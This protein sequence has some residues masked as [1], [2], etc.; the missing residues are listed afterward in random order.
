[1]KVPITW[2]R[3]FV[4]FELSIPELAHRLTLAGLEVEEIRFVGLP[5]PEEKVEGHTSRKRSIGTNVTGLTWDPEKFVVGA[6]LE[7]MP[8]PDADRL[9]LCRLDDG[10]QEHIVLTGAPNLFPYKGQGILKNPLKVAYAREGATLFDGHIAGWETF[11]LKRAKIR[12]VESYSMA[13]SEKE[14]GIS[15]EHEGIIVLDE[16]APTGKPLAEYMG[17]AVLD[18]TLTPNVARNANILGVAREVAALTGSALK[19]PSYEVDGEG[20]AIEGRVSIDIRKP[21]LNPRFVLG[22]VEGVD[23]G[24]SPYW[25]QLRLQL[26]GMRPINN[27][28]D[29]TNY[30][31]LEIGEPLH[32]FDFDVLVERARGEPPEI[33]TRLP[34]SKERINTLDAVERSLDDFTVLVADT[35]G[36]LSIAGVMG[37]AESEVSEKTTRVL[38]EGATWNYINIRRTAGSQNLQS[39]A[40]YRF[41]RG[42]HP[43]MA[44]R[45]VK[46][47]LSWIQQFAGG[48]IAKGLVDEYPLPPEPS[49]VEISPSDV[50]RSLGILLET[51]AIEEIL[52]LLGF[53][54]ERKGDKLQVTTPDHRM[55]IGEGIVGVAD[56]MEEVA[57][58]YGYDRL[59]E[60]MI[61][62]DL[63]PQYSN[64][65]LE[66]EE[67]IRN[68]LAGVDLQEIVTYRLTTPDHETRI[69]P[70][71]VKPDDRPYIQ[72]ENPISVDRVVMRHSLLASVL[73]IVESNARF[74]ERIAV[75]EIG[76]VYLSAE[77]GELPI[78]PLKLA[79]ALT[80]P[81]ALPSWRE[82]SATEFD[83]YDLKGILEA[84]FAGLKV[85]AVEYSPGQHPSFHPGK[86]A[87]ILIDGKQVGV[88]GELHPLVKERYNFQA[89]PLLAAELD[90][91]AVI[92][93]IPESIDVE[94]VK[95]FPPVLEDLAIVVDDA[96]PAEQVLDVIRKS[97]G[98]LLEDIR[99]FD[100]YRGEQIEAGKKS[101]AYA[102]TY[103]ALDRTLTDEEV[104]GLRKKIVKAL[105][106][107]LGAHL[108]S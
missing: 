56:L 101:L 86:C 29:A 20:P 24:P 96:I 87:R 6:V 55:D 82:P 88:M 107:E 74:Q 11:T 103:Q 2:L 99:L 71:G 34:E 73:E 93:A 35:A 78:E 104:A 27:I 26:A 33:I 7:V 16:D 79:I 108:R 22:L 57:R 46:R 89:F 91:E 17:D 83:F 23:V 52:G 100:L 15:E 63:P 68:L 94:L 58:I 69:L 44:E 31:M 80:G 32:A 60:T 21:E 98:E 8:H 61:S 13:C 48:E 1:M 37:G 64:K 102:L 92:R 4:D 95:T 42:I 49:I 81:R 85:G 43:A 19:E 5:L 10:E 59:P 90:V 3:E 67:Q 40:S 45:G 18:I 51:D 84:L 39:E 9:V 62:D 50:E 47:G 38:L 54:I 36:A 72:L 14:L 70:A 65:A 76:P 28:V 97:G 25:V 41:E 30:A 77:D 12:G 75:F 66:R 105:E 53:E 106:K